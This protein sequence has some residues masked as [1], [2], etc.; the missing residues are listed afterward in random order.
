MQHCK[1]LSG[2]HAA[3]KSLVP[4]LR[5]VTATLV[6]SVS[7]M[8]C[9]AT[10]EAASVLIKDDRSVRISGDL[11]FRPLDDDA[12]I[13]R[14]PDYSD[15]RTADFG[16]MFDGEAS[17]EYLFDSGARALSGIASQQSSV[18]F[19]TPDSF[20][21]DGR[22]HSFISAS[23]VGS[24]VNG[25]EFFSSASDSFGDAQSRMALTIQLTSPTE[26]VIEVVDTIGSPYSATPQF[27]AFDTI[28]VEGSRSREEPVRLLLDAGVYSVFADTYAYYG[29]GGLIETSL[30]FSISG[31]ALRQSTAIPT[32]AALPGGLALLAALTTRR[33]RH[34]QFE[35]SVAPVG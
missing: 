19:S 23:T 4:G 20:R 29:Y 21:I 30:D 31:R 10:A 14:F 5:L 33:R 25:R 35:G 6:A 32:P 8:W 12:I 28:L 11:F 16:Q 27:V 24:D 9:S 18:D 13:P 17:I 1:D 22:L 3:F 26:I 34:D 15:Y 7:G 2:R